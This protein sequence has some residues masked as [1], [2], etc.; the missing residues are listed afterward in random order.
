M[1]GKQRT[2]RREEDKRWDEGNEK[3]SGQEDSNTYIFTN[4]H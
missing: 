3:K 1:K 2:G 4:N